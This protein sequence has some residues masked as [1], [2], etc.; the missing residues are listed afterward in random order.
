VI[1]MDMRVA[2]AAFLLISPLGAC[3]DA[4]RVLQ[5]AVVRYDAAQKVLVVKDECPPHREI[6]FGL[7]EAEVGADA[8]AHDV[9]RVAY[10]EAGGQAMATRVMNL[11]RQKEGA[12]TAR[13]PSLDRC[14]SVPT[15]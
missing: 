5:G 4:P 2:L 7:A 10:R 15:K 13:A 11:T 9:V 1:L 6:S 12:P 3:V 8:V 14:R